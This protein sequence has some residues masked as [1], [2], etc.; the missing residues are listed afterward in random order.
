VNI[1]FTGKRLESSGT[2]VVPGTAPVIVHTLPF[3]RLK[4]F[5]LS[6]TL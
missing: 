3:A 2:A 6:G 4:M 5:E 1:D